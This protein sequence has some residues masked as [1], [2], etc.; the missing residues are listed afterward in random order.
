VLCGKDQR[1]AVELLVE[2]DLVQERDLAARNN[3]ADGDVCALDV[4]F[5]TGHT[6]I[7]ELLL[8]RYG[9]LQLPLPGTGFIAFMIGLPVGPPS[10]VPLV[11]RVGA[12]AK[13]FGV[14]L[15]GPLP[16]Q[17]SEVYPISITLVVDG[18]DEVGEWL[19][20]TYGPPPE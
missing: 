4:A 13:R 8:V 3:H 5:M 11:D 10:E 18:L 2:L 14:D 16:W 12:M 19:F 7:A 15:G 20:E 17:G 1:E 6:Q 9:Q